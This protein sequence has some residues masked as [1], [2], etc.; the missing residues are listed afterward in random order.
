MKGEEFAGVRL[1]AIR[2]TKQPARC[3]DVPKGASAPDRLTCLQD[4]FRRGA[5]GTEV[6]TMKG[7]CRVLAVELELLDMIVV[8]RSWRDTFS[9]L[10]GTALTVTNTARN[11]LTMPPLGRRPCV[12]PGT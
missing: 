9:I 1:A 2:P 8:I 6:N 7:D 11:A 3:A 10:M 5:I 4:F 12:S